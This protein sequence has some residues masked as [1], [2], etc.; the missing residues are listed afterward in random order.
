[1]TAYARRMMVRDVDDAA[2]LIE[3]MPLLDWYAL[4]P[5][6]TD[7]V[8]ILRDAA[9]IHPEVAPPADW[10]PSPRQLTRPRRS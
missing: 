3:R 8:R 6:L 10:L 4:R 7:A 2:E 1:V 5:L 9:Q